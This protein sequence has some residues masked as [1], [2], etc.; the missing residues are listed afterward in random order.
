MRSWL[1]HIILPGLRIEHYKE[2]RLQ[3][4][5]PLTLHT[6]QLW[7]QTE[8]SSQDVDTFRTTLIDWSTLI[9]NANKNTNLCFFGGFYCECLEH[10][11]EL[12]FQKLASHWTFPPNLL[13]R[14]TFASVFLQ[15]DCSTFEIATSTTFCCRIYLKFRGMEDCWYQLDGSWC[16]LI[17]HFAKRS[18]K[19]NIS[20]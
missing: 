20:D 19:I 1:I 6:A 13:L 16:F 15:S 3:I 8:Y 11:R 17:L 7:L 18:F 4:C 10:Y 2:V 14:C 5:A 12:W 9:L